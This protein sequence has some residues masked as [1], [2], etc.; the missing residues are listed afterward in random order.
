MGKKNQ[1]KKT[2]CK[3]E[4]NIINND[5]N[6][7]CEMKHKKHKLLFEEIHRHLYLQVSQRK[8]HYKDEF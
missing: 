1:I 6:F 2:L 7:V 3:F 4:E 5:K 8:K